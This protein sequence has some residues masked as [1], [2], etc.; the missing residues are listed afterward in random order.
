ML[1]MKMKIL[2][3]KRDISLIL[4]IIYFREMERTR[5][6]YDRHDRSQVGIALFCIGAVI[7]NRIN[8]L[9]VPFPYF[10]QISNVDYLFKKKSRLFI[11][12]LTFSVSQTTFDGIKVEMMW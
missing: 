6:N 1:D 12:R 10:N 11:L 9:F 2:Y 5:Q 3:Y 4:F 7:H 8:L